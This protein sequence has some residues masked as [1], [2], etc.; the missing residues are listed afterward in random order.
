MSEHPYITPE[1]NLGLD[2]MRATEAAAL[3]AG[4]WAGRGQKESGDGA[5]VASLRNVLNNVPM[6]GT[7]VIGE[8]EKDE[9]PMLANGEKVGTGFGPE[10]DIAVDPVDGTRL[11]A[12]GMRNSIAV[13]A[14]AEG[15]SM[16]DP[17]EC[18]YMDKLVVGA[19][20]ADVIELEAPIG[21]N[22]R[23]VAK[24]KGVAVDDITV[25]VL[26]RE[27]HEQLTRDIRDAGARTRMI[28]DGDV[29]AAVSAAML[30]T[31]IDLVAGIG[32]SPEGVVMA[33]AMI[34]LGGRILAQLKPTSPEERER[35]IAAGHDPDRILDTKDLVRSDNVIFVATGITEGDLVRGVRYFPNGGAQ[36]HSVVMRSRSGTVRYVRAIHNLG[37][38]NRLRA[39][40]A[41]AQDVFSN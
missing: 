2:L 19:E 38:V 29:A 4:L 28:T 3:S 11:L 27:R 17:T 26:N 7:I 1:T 40:A 10:V 36:T 12:W 30:D 24:A 8:G 25:A 9:A 20:G 15:G 39:E 23:R 41:D 6:R 18:F 14:A 34:C 37:K 13:L 31:E 33:A 21:E 22:I 5:A 35:T 16:Y 32:G